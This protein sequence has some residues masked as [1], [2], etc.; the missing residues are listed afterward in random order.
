MHWFGSGVTSQAR[1]A[2]QVRLRQ[3]VSVA[4]PQA[5]QVPPLQV[6]PVPVHAPPAQQGWPAPPQSAQSPAP[7][8]VVPAWVQEFPLQ[9]MFPAVPHVAQVPPAQVVPVSV[10]LLPLQQ[11][12][13][14]VPQ[15]VLQAP[16][17]QVPAMPGH[18]SPAL[19]QSVF[20]QQ[21][22]APQEFPAQ[23]V[24]PWPPH[25]WQTLFRH[26]VPASLQVPTFPAP[27]QQP[28]PAVPQGEQVP[29]RQV[30]LAP[31]H[32]LF[33]QQRS[34]GSPQPGSWASGLAIGASIPA[35]P[36]PIVP[37]MPAS[38]FP[39]VPAFPPMPTVPP[40]PIAPPM[41][42]SLFPPAP[43]M[44][45]PA[46]EPPLA[47]PLAPDPPLPIIPPEPLPPRPP[48]LVMPPAPEPPEPPPPPLLAPPSSLPPSTSSAF[49]AL[50]LP[51]QPAATTAKAI[52]DM[53]NTPGI[54][55]NLVM[56]SFLPAQVI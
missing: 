48:V 4:P 25:F 39:P 6:A 45:P 19:V 30:L 14:V 10:Q 55:R 43:P 21:P 15:V 7:V 32:T 20:T 44:L 36:L 22:P 9:H 2:L 23:Q 11:A 41:P 35:P 13:P 24:S 18:M 37:P 52:M 54:P 49:L 56:K 31:R 3:H 53:N 40:M 47:W 16:A 17:V 33:A 42:P 34:P 50:E 38:L 26:W 29:P 27:G 28:R 46:P 8:Q 1:P 12:L 5:W 51:P